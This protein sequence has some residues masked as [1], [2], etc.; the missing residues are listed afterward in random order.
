MNKLCKFLLYFNQRQIYTLL[1]RFM[2][3][4]I[5]NILN[6]FTAVRRKFSK[7]AIID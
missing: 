3:E 7:I 4:E 5:T 6:S 2:R 1:D